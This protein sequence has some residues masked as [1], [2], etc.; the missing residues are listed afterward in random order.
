MNN[1]ASDL[2]KDLHVEVRDVADLKP[3]TNNPRTH[4]SKQIRQIANSIEALGFN[5]PVLIDDNDGVIAGHGRIEAAKQLG[6]KRVPAI[7]LSHMSEAQKRAYII[8]DNKLA[9]NAGWDSE[10]LS[11]EVAHLSMMEL[12]FDIDVIGFETPEIDIMLDAGQPAAE[13]PIPTPS[14]GPCVSQPGDLWLLGTHRLYCGDALNSCSY[15]ALLAGERAA[16]V[17]T[18]PPYNVLVNGHV[19]GKGAVKHDEFKMASGEMSDE[20]FAQFL[21]KLCKLLVAYSVDGSVHFICM[22]WRHIRNLLNAGAITFTE[23]LNLC[24]WNKTNGG[25]GSLYRSKH[26]LVAVFRN[27]SASH[28]NNVELGRFGR[29]RTNV[30]D[31]AGVNA[32]SKDRYAA[33]SMHPTVK[34]IAMVADAILDVTPRNGLVLDPFSGSGTTIM[35]GEQTGRRVAAMELDPKYVDVAIR[36]FESATVVEAVLAETGE[37]FAEVAARRI[38]APKTEGAA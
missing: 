27:G 26:E 29:N 30:W 14:D 20:E 15:D 12:D 33:L 18:D 38:A 6:M 1:L 19:C 36:R 17:V 21:L 2:V 3:Y 37:T 34:P 35:A 13:P 16:T 31:Y 22:D 25:M 7:R 10:L 32:F 23:L 4:S 28:T 9:E 11:V 8:A 5:N 24:V